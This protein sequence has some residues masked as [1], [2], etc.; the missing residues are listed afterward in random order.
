[1]L[2]LHHGTL[3]P[4]VGFEPTSP[5]GL[6]V[7]QT[8][9]HFV[10]DLLSAGGWEWIQPDLNRHLLIA[11]QESYQIGRWTI[12]SVLPITPRDGWPAKVPT[13]FEPAPPHK[14]HFTVLPRVL[15][16]FNLAC[17]FYTKAA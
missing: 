4:A 10:P 17:N 11:K 3:M 5:S 16:V 9:E 1:M 8:V 6:A 14:C 2:R 7:L 15:Q 12:V 13:G